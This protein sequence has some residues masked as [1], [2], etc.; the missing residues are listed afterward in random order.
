MP[1][2]VSLGSVALCF[3]P[4]AERARG[5]KMPVDRH[6]SDRLGILRHLPHIPDD[7]PQTNSEVDRLHTTHNI[8]RQRS[9]ECLAARH[10]FN[11]IIRFLEIA[12]HQGVERVLYQQPDLIAVVQDTLRKLRVD[13]LRV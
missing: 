7:R 4:S 9:L 6:L 11:T 2:T 8:S 10:P 1:E 5:L 3:F 12:L 13:T